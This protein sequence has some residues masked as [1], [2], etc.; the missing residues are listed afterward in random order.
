MSHSTLGDLD[1][2]KRVSEMLFHRVWNPEHKVGIRLG[3]RYQVTLITLGEGEQ[4][5]TGIYTNL[6]RP[7]QG[8]S[9]STPLSGEAAGPT[10]QTALPK[11]VSP[12][13]SCTNPSDTT[14][15]VT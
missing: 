3:P 6:L 11:V 2:V 4:V 9:Q 15:L 1:N 13:N 14:L 10:F 5:F 7:P 8:G 12:Q